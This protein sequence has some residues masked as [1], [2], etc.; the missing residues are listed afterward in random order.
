MPKASFDDLYRQTSPLP[1][2]RRMSDVG[3]R[4]PEKVLPAFRLHLS[5]FRPVRILDVGAS[6]GFNA[7]LI[8]HGFDWESLPDR[9]DQ[10][11]DQLRRDV[12]HTHDDAVVF[13][14]LDVSKNALRF[15]SE[16]GLSD[17]SICMDL[18]VDA[19]SPIAI[20]R[21]SRIDVII[22]TGCIG[23]VRRVGVREAPAPHDAPALVPLHRRSRVR[24][25]RVRARVRTRRLST[26]PMPSPHRPARLHVRTGAARPD[27]ARI[28]ALRPAVLFEVR[29]LAVRRGPRPR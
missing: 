19:V 25:L 22:S 28:R 2:L 12:S 13:V 29:R 23:Y 3:Y 15:A 11:H 4:L 21:L 7:A 18:R 16:V 20:D 14:A 10:P 8:R 26:S 1:Y 5:R 6:Y 9:L 27:R 17:E 24:S